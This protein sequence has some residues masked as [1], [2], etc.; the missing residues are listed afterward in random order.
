MKEPWNELEKEDRGKTT[1]VKMESEN[2]PS[3]LGLTGYPH[4]VLVKNGAVSKTVG[5][6]M[7][8]DDLKKQL[9][10][11][12]RGG[13]RRTRSRRFRRGVRKVAHRTLRNHMP[14]VKRLSTTG[15]RR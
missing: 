5:G 9:F 13:R 2:I 4:F 6:E 7:P 15:G 8:K 12:L 1:F 11:G 10:G 14:L 3:D